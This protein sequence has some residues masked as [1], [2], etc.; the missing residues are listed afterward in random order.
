M[1]HVILNGVIICEADYDAVKNPVIIGRL[2][3]SAT[4]YG[5]LRFAQNDIFIKATNMGL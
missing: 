1:F 5:I 2:I 4:D 3:H